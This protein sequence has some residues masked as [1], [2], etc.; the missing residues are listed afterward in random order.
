MSSCLLESILYKMRTRS[1]IQRMWHDFVQNEDN[2]RTRVRFSTIS[3]IFWS[4]GADFVQ[5]EVSAASEAKRVVQN[6]LQQTRNLVQ[7]R[8]ISAPADATKGRT[9]QGEDKTCTK[10]APATLRTSWWYGPKTPNVKCSI[11]ILLPMPRS[12]ISHAST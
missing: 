4:A 12:H 7:N 9:R 8:A 3:G 11:C 2:M 1:R 5:S 10:S 6:R